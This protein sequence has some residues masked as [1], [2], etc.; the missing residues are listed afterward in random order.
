MRSCLCLH[1]SPCGRCSRGM[2]PCSASRYGRYYRSSPPSA[3]SVRWR[4]SLPTIV[5]CPDSLDSRSCLC[6][7]SSPCG[8]CSRGR[9]CSATR[10]GRC[11]RSIRPLVCISRRL[12]SLPPIACCSG[13]PYNLF[14]RSPCGTGSRRSRHTYN[15][16]FRVSR[17]CCN[18]S[19]HLSSL[20][21]HT[22][23]PGRCT[24]PSNTASHSLPR[25]GEL[26]IQ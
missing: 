4:L 13:N 14:H 8:R 6:R 17:S 18:G 7:R 21:I 24:D 26:R 11:Y 1:S 22:R 12:S 10:R 2:T 23:V 15:P 16:F 5:Y 3:C 20:W 25:R 9:R 19:S